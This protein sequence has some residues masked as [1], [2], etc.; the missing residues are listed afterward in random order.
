[1]DENIKSVQSGN[2]SEGVRKTDR[3]KSY[4]DT[5]TIPVKDEHSEMPVLSIDTST[6]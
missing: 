3:Y 5:T 1:M 4:D 2:L 6:Y